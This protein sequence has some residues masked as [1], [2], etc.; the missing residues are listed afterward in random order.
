MLR[1]QTRCRGFEWAC[2]IRDGI[3]KKETR[4]HFD[5]R[6]TYGYTFVMKTAISINDDIYQEAE[7]T[8]KRLGLSAADFILSP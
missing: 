5:I 7:Q 6:Y 8:A 1:C 4:S 3:L 2:D